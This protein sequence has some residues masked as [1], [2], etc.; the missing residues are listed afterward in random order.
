MVWWRRETHLAICHNGVTPSKTKEF[1]K[2]PFFL[3]PNGSKSV[4]ESK[5]YQKFKEIRDV[6]VN[7]LAIDAL[8]YA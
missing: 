5:I 2:S 8:I 4:T 1:L 3:D 6:T 7:L